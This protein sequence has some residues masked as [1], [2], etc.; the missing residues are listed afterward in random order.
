MIS[1]RIYLTTALN[2]ID[3]HIPIYMIRAVGNPL[4]HFICP[5]PI[6]GIIILSFER[7][8]RITDPAL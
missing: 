4:I 2:V 1:F 3:P 6:L 8:S 7:F 5:T